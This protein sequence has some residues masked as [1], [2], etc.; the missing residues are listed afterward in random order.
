MQKVF[1]HQDL[2]ISY[3]DVGVGNVVVL[4]HGFGEDGNIWKQQVAYLAQQFRV[5]VPD[6][7]GSGNSPLLKKQDVSIEDYAH[8]IHQLIAD[9]LPD[10][11][12]KITLLGH[13]MG[14]YITLSYAKL[15]PQKLNAFGLIHSTAFA[16]SEEKK[17]V[18]LRGIETITQ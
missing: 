6:I 11:N 4:L 1:T 2:V 9:I 10:D 13:S 8:C 14:G 18:R 17:Q 7:P 16:D 15:F 5:I 12:N 3:T